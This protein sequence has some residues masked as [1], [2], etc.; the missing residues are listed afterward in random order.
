[1]RSVRTKRLIV[2]VVCNLKGGTAKTTSSVFL[3]HALVLLGYK[4]MLC[5]ADPTRSSLSWSELGDF[6]FATI[7]LAVKNLHKQ[8]PGIVGDDI[9]VAIID[10]PPVEDHKNIVQS[11]MRLATV[12]VVTTAPTSIEYDRLPPVFAALEEVESVRD[13]DQL[14]PAAV[15]LNRCVAGAS[16]TEVY[17]ESITED[18]HRVLAAAI[19]RLELYAQSFPD[20]VK[21]VGLYDA[22][23]REILALAGEQ[24]TA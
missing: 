18:G 12:V 22:A 16:S 6:P 15:L 7:G 2:I 3:A 8:L 17:R 24:V 5:D 4:V 10:C 23:A 19:P 9:D 13:D 14:P 11:A 1:M 20:P 21:K